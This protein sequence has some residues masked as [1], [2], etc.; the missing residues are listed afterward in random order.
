MT[1][2]AQNL[3][4]ARLRRKLTAT[5]AASLC[6]VG[7]ATWFAYESG[8]TSPTLQGLVKLAHDLGVTS[9][10]LLKGVE[11]QNGESDA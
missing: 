4:R 11:Y 8:S 3:K 10:S 5:E 7:R 6:G 1:T 9:A 2:F